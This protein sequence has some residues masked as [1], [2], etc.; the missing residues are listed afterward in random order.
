MVKLP[1][2]CYKA[3]NLV[4]NMVKLSVDKKAWL[5]RNQGHKMKLQLIEVDPT[6]FIVD[7]SELCLRKKMKMDTTLEPAERLEKMLEEYCNELKQLAKV[8]IRFE[9]TGKLRP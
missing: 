2:E 6:T 9:I 4:R 8:K 1:A 5:L 7:V 3:A